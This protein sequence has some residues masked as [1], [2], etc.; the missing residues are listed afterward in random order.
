MRYATMRPRMKVIA[1]TMMSGVDMGTSD[2][3]LVERGI[4]VRSGG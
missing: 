2:E 4:Y 3:R 1:M